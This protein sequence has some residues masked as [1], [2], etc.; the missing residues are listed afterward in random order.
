MNRPSI[1]FDRAADYYDATRGF[2]PGVETDAVRLFVQAGALN[3]RSR[4][5]EIGVGTGRIA[6]P[7]APSVGAYIGID[8]SEPMLLRLREKQTTEPVSVV[9]GDA[10]RLP[11]ASRAFDAA[12]AV[13]IF[14]L[15]PDWRA[16]L[17]EAARALRPGGVLMHGYGQRIGHDGLDEFIDALTETARQ[18]SGIAP[19]RARSAFL[20]EAGWQPVGEELAHTFTSMRAPQDIVEGFRARIWSHTWDMTDDELEEAVARLQNFIDSHYDEPRAPRPVEQ[21]FRVRT[22]RPPYA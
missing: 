21:V 15:I 12:V 16:A 14:H 17:A 4:V 11:F 1:P 6:L 13:H 5:L 8:L 9:R 19:R 18:R 7:L 2:P 22:Y 3:E 10:T 20:D